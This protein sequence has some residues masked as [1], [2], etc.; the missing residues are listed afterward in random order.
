MK[1]TIYWTMQHSRR[2]LHELR[3]RATCWWLS[4][5]VEFLDWRLR[6]A[7]APKHFT[8]NDSRLTADF[9][10]ILPGGQGGGRYALSGMSS[11]DGEYQQPS[12][13]G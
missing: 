2:A 8:I 12:V 3:F 5:Q 11:C 13:R 7:L 9:F 10:S 1:P 4:Q 6:H